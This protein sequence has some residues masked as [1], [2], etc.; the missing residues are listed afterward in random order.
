[1]S[2]YR[3]GQSLATNP[4]TNRA[5]GLYVSQVGN[6][7]DLWCWENGACVKRQQR[8]MA[9]TDEHIQLGIGGK[10]AE[11]FESEYKAAFR[12]TLRILAYRWQS[13][14]K[15]RLKMEDFLREHS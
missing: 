13:L 9:I 3:F 2:A 6:Y 14:S 5:I 11:S 7:V 10:P 12:A 4:Y 8:D 15:D 1:M